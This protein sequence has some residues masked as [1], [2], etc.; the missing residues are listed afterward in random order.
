M[1]V[2]LSIVVVGVGDG[3]FDEVTSTQTTSLV[4]PNPYTDETGRGMRTRSRVSK[5]NANPI[6]M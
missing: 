4:N 6:L 5:L 3:P 1:Q 2:A